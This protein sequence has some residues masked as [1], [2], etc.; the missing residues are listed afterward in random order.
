M[1][2]IVGNYTCG[3]AT[4]VVSVYRS[5]IM[6]WVLQ[7][8]H[9]V[10]SICLRLSTCLC[11]CWSHGCTVQNGWTD[12][13]GPMEPCI[14]WG[15]NAPRKEAIL[16]G[17]SV[18]CKALGVSAVVYAAKGVIQLSTNW[19]YCVEYPQYSIRLEALGYLCTNCFLPAFDDA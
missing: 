14:R 15:G 18:H 10:W 13:C 11:M 17:C 12:A 5:H 6:H 16:G 3:M 7:M 9:V 19:L 1:R 4:C 2:Y 8:S